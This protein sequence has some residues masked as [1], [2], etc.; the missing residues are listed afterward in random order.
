MVMKKLG[1]YHG[2]RESLEAAK[3]IAEI[4]IAARKRRGK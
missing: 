4:K 3:L 2:D 1:L